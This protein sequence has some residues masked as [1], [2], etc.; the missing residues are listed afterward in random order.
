[1]R[2]IDWDRGSPYTFTIEDFN[3]LIDSNKLWARKFSELK[4]EKIVNSIYST[5]VKK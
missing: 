2:Y 1:L 4:D 3:V 5:F